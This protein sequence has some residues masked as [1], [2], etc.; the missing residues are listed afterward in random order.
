MISW[1]LL[2]EYYHPLYIFDRI[3]LDNSENR[4]S[5][6]NKDDEVFDPD[7]EM[8]YDPWS[9]FRW[10]YDNHESYTI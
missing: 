6:L 1:R 4:G 5:W 7:G 10:V 3:L 8:E 2:Y 9:Y